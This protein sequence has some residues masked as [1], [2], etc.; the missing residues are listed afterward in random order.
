MLPEC[1]RGSYE[2]GHG[3]ADYP[4]SL[5]VSCRTAWMQCGSFSFLQHLPFRRMR[6]RLPMPGRDAVPA[7]AQPKVKVSAETIAEY[8]SLTRERR[9]LEQRARALKTR[10]DP[11]HA[12]LTETLSAA[13]KGSIVRYGYRLTFVRGK[14]SVAW[15]EEFVRVA[16]ADEADRL[17]KEATPS[18]TLDVQPANPEA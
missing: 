9:E 8:L 5:W 16:G 6:P 2:A 3:R 4:R 12:A 7:K 1:G 14:A 10:T 18:R 15:K 17:L 11:I 13:G